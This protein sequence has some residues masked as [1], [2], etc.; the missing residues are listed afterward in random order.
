MRNVVSAAQDHLVI[1]PLNIEQVTLYIGKIAR[2]R[3]AGTSTARGVKAA[4]SVAVQVAR[5]SCQIDDAKRHD[6]ER[7]EIERHGEF[8]PQ[9]GTAGI[10]PGVGHVDGKRRFA[11]WP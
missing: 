6:L 8:L 5:V 11:R 9:I 3:Q 10:D 4:A 7:T 1:D 2:K